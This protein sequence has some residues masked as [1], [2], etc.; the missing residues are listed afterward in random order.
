MKKAHKTD[1]IFMSDDEECGTV[2]AIFSIVSSIEDHHWCDYQR[3]Q[4]Y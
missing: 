1:K 2:N 3:I 4:D